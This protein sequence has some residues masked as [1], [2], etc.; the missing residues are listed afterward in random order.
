ML[1]PLLISREFRIRM[2]YGAMGW[3]VVG[4][5]L[6]LVK[7]PA[8]PLITQGVNLCFDHRTR[9]PLSGQDMFKFLFKNLSK[10]K[11]KRNGRLCLILFFGPWDTIQQGNSIHCETV[12]S[13]LSGRLFV[14]WWRLS[15]WVTWVNQ[16]HVGGWLSQVSL[17]G[18]E[19]QLRHFFI[20]ITA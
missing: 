6:F 14:G 12:L 10:K 16:V 17:T 13:V 9:R 3:G 8:S 15:G 20:S 7:I 19:D 11:R 1:L 5:F 4:G 2:E 18:I